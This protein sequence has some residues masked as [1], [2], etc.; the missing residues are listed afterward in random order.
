MLEEEFTIENA[1]QLLDTR[2]GELMLTRPEHIQL[3]SALTFVQKHCG[4]LEQLVENYKVEIEELT[5][6]VESFKNQ[7]SE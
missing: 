6:L 2:C 4:E 3:V 7:K 5:A 1:L